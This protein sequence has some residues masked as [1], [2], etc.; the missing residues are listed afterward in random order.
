MEEFKLLF[1]KTDDQLKQIL[2]HA[3][4][5]AEAIKTSPLTKALE[6]KI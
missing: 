3:R 1:I 5:K 4:Q 6:L 2:E